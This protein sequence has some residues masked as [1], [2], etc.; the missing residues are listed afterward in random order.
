MPSTGEICRNLTYLGECGMRE[1]F[2]LQ[3][4]FFSGTRDDSNKPDFDAQSLNIL[5][6]RSRATSF[7][8]VDL[9]L[10]NH[11]PKHLLSNLKDVAVVG[12]ATTE[13]ERFGSKTVSELCESLTPRYHFSASPGHLAFERAPY[14]HER[15]LRP[16]TRF[17]GLAESFNPRKAK[18]LYAFNVAPMR[19]LSSSEICSAPDG[20]TL[21][22]FAFVRAELELEKSKDKKRRFDDLEAADVNRST[23]AFFDPQRA[24]RGQAYHERQE[25]MSKQRSQASNEESKMHQQRKDS[26]RDRMNADASN[27]HPSGSTGQ[28][29]RNRENF[30]RPRTEYSRARF[31]RNDPRMKQKIHPLMQRNG[32][33]FC[34]SNP[35]VEE[36]LV[37]SI[38]DHNYLALAKGGLSSE[39]SLLIPIEHS[40]T[41]ENTSSSSSKSLEELKQYQRAL[42]ECYSKRNMDLIFWER[43]LDTSS[44]GAS[45][46]SDK[47]H[48]ALQVLPLDKNMFKKIQDGFDT[49]LEHFGL[50]FLELSELQTVSSVVGQSGYLYI[51]IPC[52]VD[53]PKQ[54]SNQENSNDVDTEKKEEKKVWSRKRLVAIIPDKK[55][56]PLQLPRR[57]IAQALGTPERE[58]WK[59]CALSRDDEDA[60]CSNMKEEFGPFDF[61]LASN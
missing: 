11:W 15:E 30:D 6:S 40:A 27:V 49:Q 28:Q 1:V 33:W 56:V 2:G 37:V 17:V 57:V 60:A 43:K 24:Q 47:N 45:V 19:S 9:L 38:G 23:Q 21:S 32:C 59:S 53:A 14:S 31:D 55:R 48:A 12:L 58:D 3:V 4:A 44:S 22:P 16:P 20:T 26:H 41:L 7:V 54:E 34:L 25:L 61:T 10:T 29:H 35:S 46:A 51:D 8:G 13:Q 18:F 5:Q 39:H 42:I 36:H 52:E 50:L